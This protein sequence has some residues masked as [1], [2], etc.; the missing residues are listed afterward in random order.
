MKDSACLRYLETWR[1]ILTRRVQRPGMCDSRSITILDDFRAVF[2]EPSTWIA[3]SIPSFEGVAL[4]S[5]I[6]WRN[7]WSR[8][9]W[10]RTLLLLIVSRIGLLLQSCWISE[11]RARSTDQEIAWQTF[12]CV[13]RNQD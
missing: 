2:K 11:S 5:G 7:W 8:G 9:V 13:S 4:S 1:R 12:M 3:S 10:V 6:A